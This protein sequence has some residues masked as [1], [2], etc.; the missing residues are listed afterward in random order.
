M[1]PGSS[2]G[3]QFVITRSIRAIVG[4][5]EDHERLRATAPYARVT[6]QAAHARPR[7]LVRVVRPSTWSYTK[8]KVRLGEYK[9]PG[10]ISAAA[11]GPH[12]RAA[13]KQ[14]LPRLGLESYARF[15]Q[16]LLWV[17]EEQMRYVVSYYYLPFTDA[18]NRRN[19]A[20]FDMNAVA[21]APRH[22]GYE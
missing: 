18:L 10:E 4:S 17:E 1:T 13:I 21:I 15:F 14:F 16:V 12:A 7:K 22:P 11:F 20:M 8:W 3:Q 19:L 9:I 6:P 5:Q 2:T